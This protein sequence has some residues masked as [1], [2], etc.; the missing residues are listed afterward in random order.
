MAI[1]LAAAAATPPA[2]AARRRLGQLAQLL[3]RAVPAG[4]FTGLIV[5]KNESIQNAAAG[6]LAGGD[7]LDELR[8]GVTLAFLLLSA[9]F[10]LLIATMF[11]I[12]GSARG[13]ARGLWPTVLALAG[14]LGAGPLAMM[15]M[16]H[17]DLRL[18]I[19]ADLVM[20]VG[21]AGCC[22]TLTSLGRCF[23][24]RP[25]ARGLVTGGVYRWV[26]HPLYLFEALVQVGT[27]MLVFS[28]VALVVFGAFVFLQYGRTL[29][30]EHVLVAAFPEYAAY[31]ARTARFIP[32]VL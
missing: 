15:P 30:E 17:D 6:V 25:C 18:V 21:M 22:L 1:D 13:A 19:A 12:R 14:T 28:P 31:R 5:L 23:G 20:V 27:L 8:A 11:V 26:R 32:G 16:Q 24:I 29:Q 10:Y 3:A 7:Q 2:L 4:F 9:A